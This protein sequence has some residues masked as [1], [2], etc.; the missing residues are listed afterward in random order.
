MNKDH[1]HASN[2]PRRTRLS[3]ALAAVLLSGLAF[4]LPAQANSVVGATP[5]DIA[6]A[7]GVQSALLKDKAF[8]A[9]NIDIAVRA[10]Q[11]KVNLSGWVGEAGDDVL[12]RKIA[13]SVGGV[14]TVTSN[15][16][17]WSSETD[18]RTGVAAT[19]PNPRAPNLIGA[20]SADLALAGNVQSALMKDKAFQAAD[21]DI[22]VRASMGKVNLS[23]WV[24]DVNDDA[25]AR[26]IAASVGGVSKV[27]TNLRSWSTDGED[28]A[29]LSGKT[30]M[31]MTPAPSVM[32]ATPADMALATDVRAAVMQAK[33][34]Q[35]ADV[36][37]VVRAAQGRV[38]LS[39][40]ISYANND[41]QARKIAATVPGVKSVTSDFK[42][43]SSEADPRK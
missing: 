20:T 43:W 12:A 24:G 25:L 34:F 2:Q 1:V 10:W 40:W 14:K 17:S 38:N 33:T 22:V 18:D 29:G 26:K 5:E 41:I 16:R 15:L 42:S 39:G 4:A 36:D 37:L 27:T 30:N 31:S 21:V 28:R 3:Q 19:T 13:A 7:T 6:L 23:G 8:Q 35:D 32:G 11:G 9:G